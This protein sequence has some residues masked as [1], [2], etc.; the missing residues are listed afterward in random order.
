MSPKSIILLAMAL[1]CGLVAAVGINQI[2]ARPSEQAETI[3]IVVAKREIQKGEPFRP[4]DIRL[5]DWPKE[6][7]PEGALDS[8][9][10][11]ADMRSRGMIYPGEPI[12]DKKL[13]KKGDMTSLSTEFPP[14]MKGISVKVD[15]ES[16]IAGMILPGDNVDVLVYVEANPS[17]QIF[18]TETVPVEENMKVM[19][20]DDQITRPDGKENSISAKTVTLC[21][22]PKQAGRIMHATEI[23]KVRL[24]LRSGKDGT[25][26][27]TGPYS[28]STQEVLG[29][30]NSSGDA[31][32]S[33][34]N[35]IVDLPSTKDE[36]PSFSDQF[37]GGINDLRSLMNEIKTAREGTEKKEQPHI[38]VLIEGNETREIQFDSNSAGRRGPGLAQVKGS[39]ST[40]P[41][42]GE[43]SPEKEKPASSPEPSPEQLETMEK[44]F[45]PKARS[46]GL[47]EKVSLVQ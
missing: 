46:Q 25:E 40:A 45:N 12:I 43:S 3:Q 32:K 7:V 42:A 11:L 44:L 18:A 24:V 1:G 17:K 34:G 6:T 26:E 28:T 41:A 21:A 15:N 10:K 20:V 23:G 36:G 39:S 19:A 5:M 8:V 38:V 29:A 13:I 4:D 16:G 33:G 9:E 47:K 14:G 22:T 37:Q 2:M 35:K 30:K 31:P 27:S